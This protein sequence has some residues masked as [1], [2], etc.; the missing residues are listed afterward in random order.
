ME[1]LLADLRL[2]MRMLLK[3]PAFTAVSLLA[4]ALGIGANSVMF[5]VASTVLLRPLAYRDAGQLMWVQ[6][7]QQ[8][9]KTPINN[10]PPDF[11]RLRERTQSFSGVA[12]LYRNPVNLTGA[13]EPQRVRAIVASAE[14]LPVLGVAPALGRGF[15]RDDERWGSHR[16]ALLGD[17]LWHSRFGA[18]PSIVGRSITLDGQ[19]YTVA[20]ILPAGFSWLGSETQ[21]LLPMSFEPGDN[22]NSH[23]NYFVGVIGRLRPGV[24]EERARAELAGIAA[25]IGNE[26]P[27]S[28]GLTMDVESLEHS[29]VGEVRA[30]I[31]VL[32]GAAGFVLL[33]AC[34]NLA[35]LLLVRA[36][37]RRREIA[38]R[39]A[40]G[41]SRRR[42]LR[43]LLT[44]SVLLAALGGA[45]GL[46]LAFWATDALNLLGQ[47]VL[48]RMREVRVDSTVLAFTLLVSLATGVLF[49]L[50]PALHGSSID[51]R[52]SLSETSPGG[53]SGRRRLTS[54]LVV[55]E[56][57][58]AVVLLTGAGLLMKSTYRLLRVDAGFDPQGLLTA[59]ISLPARKYVDPQ[60]A[61]AFSPAAYAR[62]AAFYDEVIAGLRALPGVR[63]A[64]AVSSLPFAGDNWGKRLVLWDRPL[65]SNADELPQIQYRPVAG[66][67]FRALGIRVRGRAFTEADGVNAPPVAIV[68][69]ELARRYFQGEDPIGKVISVNVPRELVPLDTVPIDFRPQRHTIVGIAD[70]VRYGGLERAP[71]PLVY[72]P[73]A[74]GSEGFLSMSVTVRTD[75]NPL[76]LVA[77]LREQVRRADPEQAIASVSTFDARLAR[78]V[79]QPRLQTGLL[80]LFAAM[81]VL[82]AAIGIYGVMAVAVVQRTKEIGIRMALGAVRRD[83][84]AL[85]VRQGFSLAAA[86][87]LIGVAG[88]LA[89]TRVLR[90]LLFSVSA[91]DPAVFASIV[92]LLAVV[93]LVACYLPARRAARVDPMVALRHE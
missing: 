75:G 17:G 38:I 62:A 13:Q 43:Q 30:A 91:T 33:I 55:A 4:L 50:A 53:A 83:V 21:L 27:E 19:P 61:R 76:A 86:G 93:A 23:N 69:Q 46:M 63:A 40:L 88:A 8:D 37:A 15:S 2:G 22:L 41:A 45:A 1:T 72:A 73:F 67:Y 59:E 89:L 29:M 11:Y 16:V 34:A 78:A 87:L 90:S 52:E 47:E 5:S 6:T 74:Q 35:N 57:A 18:D 70:D 60:L 9:T 64:G 77:A 10:S 31:L 26:F 36:A 85:V 39:A 84:L 58:L 24:R 68:N 82:L 12:A 71:G 66:D 32:L 54:A 3:A 79:A 14:L 28:R 81:A 25:Q 48:P 44:E 20:G 56:V 51:L 80:G 92:G 7:V 49:G 42:I 65:P